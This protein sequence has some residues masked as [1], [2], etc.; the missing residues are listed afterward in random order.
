MSPSSTTTDHDLLDLLREG[1]SIANDAFKVL[2]GR[3]AKRIYAYAL[4]V[5]GTKHRASDITHDVFMRFLVAVNDGAQIEN[6][7]AYLMRITRNLCLNVRRDEL[8]LYVEPEQVDPIDTDAETPEQRDLR[9]VVV[10]A[11][12]A[13]PE[14]YREVLL[15]Q[16]Y[17]GLSYA[18]ICDVTGESLPTVR[19]RLS[20]AK[21]RLRKKLLPL[22]VV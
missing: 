6:L 14:H 13:L 1:G 17:S 21:E 3:Y 22:I 9:Q 4:K 8:M 11:I 12:D 20:R 10:K 5:L 2:Y 16:M 19:Q 7:A 18:E 15:L